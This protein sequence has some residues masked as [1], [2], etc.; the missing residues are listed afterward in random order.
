MRYLLPLTRRFINRSERKIYENRKT[1]S[2]KVN[3]GI[4]IYLGWTNRILWGGL[5]LMIC[6]ESYNIWKE[7]SKITNHT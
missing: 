5:G 3:N 2:T 6:D 7:R 4:Y 1:I